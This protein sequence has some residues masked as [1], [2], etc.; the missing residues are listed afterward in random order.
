MKKSI[1]VLWVA[2]IL[3]IVFLSLTQRYEIISTATRDLPVG[4]KIDKLTGKV[5]FLRG[6]LDQ[7]LIPVEKVKPANEKK[8]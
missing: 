7:I 6:V 5:W 8:K 4:Y 1:I 2:T 3:S